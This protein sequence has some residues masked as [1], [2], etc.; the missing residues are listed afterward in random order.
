[1]PRVEQ[2]PASEPVGREST[3]ESLGWQLRAALPPLRLH[4]LSLYDRAGEVL[5]LSE[6]ALGPDEHAFVM[7]ALGAL[8]GDPSSAH[9]ERDFGDGRAAAFLAVRSP[10]TELV[11]LVMILTDT[12][13]LS[14]GGLGA[15]VLVPQV[16]ALLQRLAILL[17]PR[18]RAAP[19]A[20]N[21]AA[22]PSA[23]P[24]SAAAPSPT[25][26]SRT[27][28]ILEWVPP[29]PTAES[30]DITEKVLAADEIERILT[31]ELA[32]DNAPKGPR[33]AGPAPRHT[34]CEI[35]LQELAKLRQGGRMR[36]FRVLP[37]RSGTA[38]P[39]QPL[40]AEQSVL[41]PLR[42]LAAW[43]AAQSTMPDSET[44]RFSFAVPAATLADGDFPHALVECIRATGIPPACIGLEITEAAWV[45]HRERAVRVIHAIERLGCFLALDDFTFDSRAVELLRSKALEL[46]N[47][48]RTLVRAALR[49]KLAQ[50]R[51][52][53]IAQAAR[54]LGIHCAAKDVDAVATQRWLSAA[55]FDYAGGPLFGAPRPLAA[56][57]GELAAR[58]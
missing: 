28:E 29:E 58:E 16:R 17:R 19:P 35:E 32:V 30:G 42:E 50:A 20:S 44:L 40:A 24:P 41:A 45:E 21:R 26:T 56:L 1:M 23:A 4:S 22:S 27:L 6:G 13:A 8:T 55:G 14:A 37:P 46:V 38:P 43:L 11:G 18:G 39:E 33:P 12:K 7:E 15:R 25:G 2:A 9:C 10:Q 57:S 51:I 49:D 3:A 47:V 52:V 34:P 53:A 48:E 31:F 5:W 36:R 54:V